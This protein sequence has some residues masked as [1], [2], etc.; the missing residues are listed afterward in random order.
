MRGRHW[1]EGRMRGQCLASD[2]TVSLTGQPRLLSSTMKAYVV[3]FWLLTQRQALWW[4]DLHMIDGKS[5]QGMMCRPPLPSQAE[6]GSVP[7]T[8]SNLGLAWGP[9]HGL[10]HLHSNSESWHAGQTG[11]LLGLLIKVC[12]SHSARLFATPWTAAHQSPLSMGFSRQGYWNGLWFP[13]PIWI[14]EVPVYPIDHWHVRTNDACTHMLSHT[15]KSIS[16]LQEPPLS[17]ISPYWLNQ[18]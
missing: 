10:I 18:F 9:E 12:A 16:L 7:A 15:C 6:P 17:R 5:A 4:E 11:W 8:S 3:Q 1:L 14:K 2:S 13:S